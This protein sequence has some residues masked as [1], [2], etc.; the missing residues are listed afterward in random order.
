MADNGAFP[1]YGKLILKG[2]MK[3]ETGLHIGAS[4]D[5]IEIGGVDNPVMRDPLTGYPYIPG[6]SLKGKLRSIAER[7][8]AKPLNRETGNGYRHECSDR[9]CRVCRLFGSTGGEQREDNIPSRLRV[10]DVF[11]T[12]ESVDMLRGID[13]PLNFTELKYENALDRVTCA[14]NPRPVERVPAGAE[15][16]YEVVYDLEEEGHCLEDLQKLLHCMAVL[17]DDYLGGHGSRGYGKIR[18]VGNRLALRSKGYYAGREEER[19]LVEGEDSI[20]RLRESVEKLFDEAIRPV[21]RKEG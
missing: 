15:F 3:C 4:R 20:S 12:P 5:I 6:S 13:T 1:F 21:F 18:F 2:A 14:A 16:A 8:E 19:S 10:R 11:L 7:L 17:E 9:E